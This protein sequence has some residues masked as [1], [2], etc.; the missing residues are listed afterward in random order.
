MVCLS[1]KTKELWDQID[2]NDKLFILGYTKSSSPSSSSSRPP[3][4]SPFPPKQCCSFNLHEMSTYEFL[5]V[6]T[7]ELEP[8]PAPDEAITENPPILDTGF[9]EE[10]HWGEIAEMESSFDDVGDYEHCI[11]VQHLVYSQRHDGNVF[12]DIFEQCVVDTQ[13]TEPLQEIVFYDAHETELGLPPED[14]PSTH[15]F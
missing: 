8:D 9:K 15:P 14:S 1:Q 2:D 11:I 4:K 5:Q 10:E 7:H 12:D 6:H 13:T 3:G